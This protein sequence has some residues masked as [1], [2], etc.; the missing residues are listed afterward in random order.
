MFEL[1]T[2]HGFPA[3]GTAFDPPSG[4]SGLTADSYS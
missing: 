3:H 4:H 2:V 1:H